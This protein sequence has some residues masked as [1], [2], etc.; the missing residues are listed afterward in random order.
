M[1]DIFLSYGRH[2]EDDKGIVRKIYDALKRLDYVLW[3]DQDVP[4]GISYAHYIAERL[5]EA[6]VVLV[7]WSRASAKSEWVYAEAEA[8]RA[9]G[10]YIGVV[11]EDCAIPLPFNTL[12]LIDFRGWDSTTDAH[13]F[14]RLA[15]ALNDRLTPADDRRRQ[16]LFRVLTRFSGPRLGSGFLGVHNWTERTVLSERIDFTNPREQRKLRDI[17]TDLGFYELDEFGDPVGNEPDLPITA[18]T[19]IGDLVEWI[20]VEDELDIPWDDREYDDG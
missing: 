13:C 9:A 14:V 5:A 17:L 15:K 8:G 1:T 10:K 6:K 18:N 4:A 11:L 7:L 20:M 3:W 19:T 12:N 2:D 16:I